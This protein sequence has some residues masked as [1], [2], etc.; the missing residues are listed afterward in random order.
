MLLLN[1]LFF[2]SFN[3]SYFSRCLIDD[4]PLP[5]SEYDILL[6]E[7]TAN[8]QSS[9]CQNESP[10]HIVDKGQS[11][12]QL[13][14]VI[15]S[16]N[17]NL[18]VVIPE[19]MINTITKERKEGYDMPICKEFDEDFT[20]NLQLAQRYG[21]DAV[22]K[23]S[24]V[25]CS[26]NFQNLTEAEQKV[27]AKQYQASWIYGMDSHPTAYVHKM[28][29]EFI[30]HYFHHSLKDLI[31]NI[32]LQSISQPPSYEMPV[33]LYKSTKLFDRNYDFQC[34]SIGNHSK[35]QSKMTSLSEFHFFQTAKLKVENVGI[36][37][38]KLA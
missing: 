11:M 20:I 6:A 1:V 3:S 9:R 29:A 27:I 21:I 10:E 26:L 18:V 15:F 36:V 17:P 30:L 14:R 25:P 34:L 2:L 24:H 12:E 22:V 4:L 35:Y 31:D 7:H 16:K 38:L 28:M 19:I 37:A 23:F 8:D 5:L 32:A 13:L 33:P